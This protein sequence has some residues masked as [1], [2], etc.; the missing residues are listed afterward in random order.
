M[1]TVVTGSLSLAE[2]EVA[3]EATHGNSHANAAAAKIYFD[4]IKTREF[5]CGGIL[6]RNDFTLLSFRRRNF[7]GEFAFGSVTHAHAYLLPLL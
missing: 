5:D 7:R 3:D 6:A 2:P 1:T 4:I